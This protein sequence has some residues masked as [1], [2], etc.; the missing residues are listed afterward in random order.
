MEDGL[1]IERVYKRLRRLRRFSQVEFLEYPEN[2]DEAVFSATVAPGPAAEILDGLK[3]IPGAGERRPSDDNIES[4]IRAVLE[5]GLPPELD[6]T[7]EMDSG[8]GYQPGEEVAPE[9]VDLYVRLP[10]AHMPAPAPPAAAP[11]HPAANVPRSEAAQKEEARRE[12]V[13]DRARRRRDAAR[14][15]KEAKTGRPVRNGK[16]G[17]VTKVFD[18]KTGL[19]LWLPTTAEVRAVMRE[20][21]RVWMRGIASGAALARH[22]NAQGL[23]PLEGKTFKRNMMPRVLRA[24][25]RYRRSRAM[26]RLHRTAR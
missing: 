25:G 11:R 10:K 20:A 8:F 13:R 16:V 17:Y 14:A 23:K 5:P 26:M 15:E 19:D 9:T 3:R 7:I 18:D 21:D 22:L 2:A 12:K 6:I 4:V 24:L 1:E